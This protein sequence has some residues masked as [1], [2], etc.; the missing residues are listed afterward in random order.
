[1]LIRYFLLNGQIPLG[2]Y[3]KIIKILLECRQSLVNSVLSTF[4]QCVK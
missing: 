3:L 1:L 2:V 4:D